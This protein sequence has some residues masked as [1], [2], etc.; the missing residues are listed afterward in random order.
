MEIFS[1][2][3]EDL[4][5][6]I[7]VVSKRKRTSVS[8]LGDRY[9]FLLFSEHD[10]FNATKG[11]SDISAMTWQLPDENYETALKTWVKPS[12]EEAKHLG[13][14]K[15]FTSPHFLM[16]Q[17]FLTSL[18]AKEQKGHFSDHDFR[19]EKQNVLAEGR[20]ERF[21]FHAIWQT[22]SV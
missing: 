22:F 4:L 21:R 11:C 8:V 5:S 3:Y 19:T 13:I 9:T 16:T 2:V 10:T 18:S 6:T 14:W 1:E 7:F 17:I 15:T 12:K 20:A